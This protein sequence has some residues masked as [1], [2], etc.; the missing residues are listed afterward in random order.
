MKKSRE[1]VKETKMTL[2]TLWGPPVLMALS[3][4][5]KPDIVFFMTDGTTG[6]PKQQI[7][8]I[9]DL[10]KRGGKR[11]T[12]HTTALMEPDAAQDLSDLA[13]ANGGDFTIVQADGKTI[14][15]EEFFKSGGAASN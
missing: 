1:I 2:G 5:P 10:N 15:G 12:I 11:A 7:E 14:K 13:K 8:M 3:I 9:N 6:N 4:R